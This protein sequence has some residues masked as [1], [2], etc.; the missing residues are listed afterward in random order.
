MFFCGRTTRL[1]TFS[2][3]LVLHVREFVLAGGWVPK[4]L[5]T[6]LSLQQIE[7]RSNFVEV[8]VYSR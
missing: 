8:S 5:G 2:D 4:K 3:Y 6:F 7:I 1:A